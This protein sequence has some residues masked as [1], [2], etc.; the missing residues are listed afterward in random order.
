[1][2]FIASWK[3][4]LNN[5]E[6]LAKNT[7]ESYIMD[8]ELF[9]RFL[10]NF[11]SETVT[12][13]SLT[14][15]TK[16][17][18]RAWVL[19]RK[20]K[21]DSEKSISRGISSIKS[22]LRFS[23]KTNVIKESDIISM[24]SPKIKRSLPRPI[25]IDKINDI[26]LSINDIKKTN[27]IIKRDKALLILIYSVGLRI[28]E[29]LGLNRA[30]IENCGDFINVLGKGSKIRMVPII[31]KVK[32]TILNYIKHLE[33]KNSEALFVNRFGERLSASAVQKLIRK[34]RKSLGLPDSVTPHALRHSCATHI[35]ENGGDLRS[36]QELLGHASISSTQIYSDVAKK[37]VSDVY[38]KC[39]PMSKKKN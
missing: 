13:E 22:F 2:K 30:D 20:N 21:G 10:T 12:K 32:E 7:V 36:V 38:D 3:E 4:Y 39:H 28:S 8:M 15:I 29:A 33:F 5:S 9:I 16:Q 27:W 23:I 25:P 1:M 17:D 14:S 19:H 24:R 35:I 11:K 37:H 6:F 26:L 31:D 18:M 34:S